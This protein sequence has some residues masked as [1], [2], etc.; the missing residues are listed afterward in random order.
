MVGDTCG[1]NL[2][3]NLLYQMLAKIFGAGRHTPPAPWSMP[4]NGAR[5]L[6]IGHLTQ[7]LRS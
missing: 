3:I 4:V 7:G 2:D 1:L 5:D 6:A